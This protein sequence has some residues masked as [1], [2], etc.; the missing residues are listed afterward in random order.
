VKRGAGDVD[1]TVVVGVFSS[2]CFV[3]VI[4][5]VRV[6]PRVFVGREGNVGRVWR[7]KLSARVRLQNF[8]ARGGQRRIMPRGFG[9]S[10]AGPDSPQ[11]AGSPSSLLAR[12]FHSRALTPRR[13]PL[14]RP[15][16][17]ADCGERVVRERWRA[18]SSRRF[19]AAC[20]RKDGRGAWARPLAAL[21]LAACAGFTLGRL[22]RPAPPPLLIERRSLP[23]PAL[24][25]KPPGAATQTADGGA[26]ARDKAAAQSAAANAEPPTDPSEIVSVRANTIIPIFFT[27]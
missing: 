4:S 10:F 11:R 2:A 12:A 1:P 17:C 27:R 15:N 6:R 20:E 25:A 18:W 26:A 21:C 14:Y 7:E 24:L 8:V 5:S 9:Q 23:V 22:M 13:L 3:S 16:F 19:C